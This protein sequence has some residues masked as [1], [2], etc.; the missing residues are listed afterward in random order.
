[1]KFQVLGFRVWGFVTRAGR[2]SCAISCAA[3][4]HACV[5]AMRGGAG[6]EGQENTRTQPPPPKKH[7]KNT[8]T[9]PSNRSARL[10]VRDAERVPQPLLTDA[11]RAIR[12][13][14][15]TRRLCAHGG[16]DV[17]RRQLHQVV[18]EYAAQPLRKKGLGLD[19]PKKGG[20]LAAEALGT[21][22]QAQHCVLRDEI[23]D[24]PMAAQLE[25][26]KQPLVVRA[27]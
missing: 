12:V 1:M 21:R 8:H 5:C 13:R 23:E 17:G 14:R 15:R 27:W 4:L 16:G 6:R 10:L 3:T 9:I 19:V 11:A 24:G 2:T 22:H 25:T 20:V 7:K 18:G 26:K